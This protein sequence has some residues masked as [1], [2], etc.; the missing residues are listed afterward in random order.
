MVD[1]LIAGHGRFKADYVAAESAFLE[2]LATAGQHPAALFIGCSDS[3][4]IPELLTG[5][6]PGELFVVRNIANRVP[7]RND[8]DTSVGAALEFAVE[9]LQV[10]DVIVCGHDQCGGIGAALDGLAGIRPG[11]ELAGWLAG[12]RPAVERA[13]T[14]DASRDV[15]LRRAVEENVLEGIAALMTFEATSTAVAAGQLRLHGWVY[16]LA[17]ATLRA[18][19]ARRDRFVPIEALGPDASDPAGADNPPRGQPRG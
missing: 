3:R 19:D 16:D 5:A 12:L 1:S 11:S 6:G 14:V 17:N 15:L 13:R 10:R 2:R 8:P 18:Y 9:Q 7:A 4:V